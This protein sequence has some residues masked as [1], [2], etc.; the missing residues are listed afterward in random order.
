MASMTELIPCR[1]VT[2][3][4]GEI[5]CALASTT[6]IKEFALRLRIDGGIPEALVFVD[7]KSGSIVDDI[8]E[9]ISA[10]LPGYCIPDLHRLPSPLSAR[11]KEF[12]FD[13][14]K[15][16]IARQHSA[17]LSEKGKLVAEIIA[18][19]LRMD[20]ADIF[21]DSDFFL[22][23]GSSLVLGQLSYNIRKQTGVDVGIP[24]LFRNSTIEG[25]ASLI[26]EAKA[27][28]RTTEPLSARMSPLGSE[29]TLHDAGDLH[30]IGARSQTNLLCMMIQAIPFLFFHPL[31]LAL[32]CGYP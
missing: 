18:N 16:E 22:L 27:R 7:E 5:E 11:K 10:R 25:I 1:L 13:E 32:S 20:P 17:T 6:A 19:L 4:E 14:L 31:R 12:D 29:E 28:S 21:G 3:D 9:A 2:V 24:M 8:E 26:D 30:S 23:G 15:K